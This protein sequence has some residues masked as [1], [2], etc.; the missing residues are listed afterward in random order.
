MYSEA[1]KGDRSEITVVLIW[2]SERRL[3]RTDS[4][5]I[6]VWSATERYDR[7]DD[8]ALTNVDNSKRLP[9]ESH[10]QQWLVLIWVTWSQGPQKWAAVTFPLGTRAVWGGTADAAVCAVQLFFIYLLPKKKKNI[11]AASSAFTAF[12]ATSSL[13]S[14]CHDLSEPLEASGP[15]EPPVSARLQF[16][17]FSIKHLL[18]TYHL[19]YEWCCHASLNSN[20]LYLQSEAPWIKPVWLCISIKYFAYHLLSLS[21]QVFSTYT[22]S[23]T[24]TEWEE[25]TIKRQL[26]QICVTSIWL[27]VEI[28]L[29]FHTVAIDICKIT[30]WGLWLPFERELGII[31]YNEFLFFLIIKTAVWKQQSRSWLKCYWDSWN[32]APSSKDYFK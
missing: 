4:V 14:S 28:I 25:R 6:R 9:G 3:T 26:F 11:C 20:V 23:H 13:T 7:L 31:K 32:L 27:K 17:Q 18:F 16:G 1:L 21:Q 5:L 2:A 19:L 22:F 8:T 15:E 24:H 10:D 30:L 12:S 29:I